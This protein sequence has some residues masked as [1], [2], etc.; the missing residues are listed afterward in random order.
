MEQVLHADDV[1]ASRGM[2]QLPE[3]DIA[4]ADPRD[5]ALGTRRHQGGQLII[6]TGTD[7]AVTGQAEVDRG[8]LAHPQ[9]AEVV[10][11]AL[12]QLARFAGRELS[13]SP[14]AADRDLADDRQSVRVG[15]ERF[16]NQVVDRPVVPG[17][18]DV[19]D[20]SRDRSPEN[21][22][23]RSRVSRPASRERAIELHRA[24]PGPPDTPPAKRE[25]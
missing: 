25:R 21:A 18:V 9:A 23:G 13:A 1:R 14:V 7:A 20:T 5:Q 19:I 11:D 17:R 6:E 16:A 10:L 8:E 3:A 24:V 12:A 4:Q 2:T 22:N 15:V